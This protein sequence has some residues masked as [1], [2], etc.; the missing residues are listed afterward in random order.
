L[1]Q[2]LFNAIDKN[3]AAHCFFDVV[4]LFVN[5]ELSLDKREEIIYLPADTFLQII[6]RVAQYEVPFVQEPVLLDI[7]SYLYQN[8]IHS[9]LNQIEEGEQQTTPAVHKVVNKRKNPERN[10]ESPGCENLKRGRIRKP[11]IEETEEQR[12]SK[13]FTSFLESL[14]I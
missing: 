13:E 7:P 3:D 5:G 9:E 8:Q 12:R 14:L 6:E 2:K 1:R 11:L 4:S 10:L